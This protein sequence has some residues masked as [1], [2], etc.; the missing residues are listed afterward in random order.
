MVKVRVVVMAVVIGMLVLAACGGTGGDSAAVSSLSLNQSFRG[1][2]ISFN[3]PEG[4]VVDER[5][6]AG[7]MLAS[8]QSTLDNMT[9]SGSDILPAGELGVVFVVLPMADLTGMYDPMTVLE[10]MYLSALSQNE[11]AELNDPENVTIGG[12][13]CARVTGSDYGNDVAALVVEVSEDALVALIA[14][15]APGEMGNFDATL[16]GIIESLSYGA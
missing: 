16:E 9:G 10:R 14:G 4:W 3:Y 13:M 11:D 5:E 12:K 7:V 6:G 8:S 1:A 15:A 2:G